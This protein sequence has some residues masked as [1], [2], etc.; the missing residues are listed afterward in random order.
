MRRVV[1]TGSTGSGKSTLAGELSRR[2]GAPHVELDAL[3]WD[4]GWQAAP[5]DVLRA[6]VDAA[7]PADAAWI[8]D[9]NYSM[10]RDIVWTRADTLVWLDYALPLVFWRLA[11]RCL[12][13]GIKHVEL[14]NGNRERLA[15]H[16]FTRDSLLLFLLKTHHQ[17]RREVGSALRRPEYAHLIVKHF[18]RPSLTEAWLPSVAHL[19]QCHAGPQAVD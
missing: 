19:N 12:V 6:R 15:E 1:V 16:L 9:G 4:P 13:R 3:H 7:V 11:R 5:L 10:V 8:V 2:L 17:R 18:R 14:Y